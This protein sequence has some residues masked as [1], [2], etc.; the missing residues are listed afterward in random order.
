MRRLHR[1]TD[2]PNRSIHALV[3]DLDAPGVRLT[4]TPSDE[5]RQTV[6]SFA[7]S[8]GVAVAVNAGFFDGNLV[9]Y[10]PG[11]RAVWASNTVRR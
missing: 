4:A 5:R 10:A 3:I 7:Q 8:K 6:S 2:G 9:V 11:S 1:T